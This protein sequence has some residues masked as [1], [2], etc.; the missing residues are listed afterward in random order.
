MIEI[1]KNFFFEIDP[2][3]AL[4]SSPRD[5]DI[6]ANEFLGC[7]FLDGKITHSLLNKLFPNNNI[8]FFPLV[9]TQIDEI[10]AIENLNKCNFFSQFN[11]ILIDWPTEFS[12]HLS[13]IN[14]SFPTPLCLTNKHILEAGV[15]EK[16][17]ATS[18]V[19]FIESFNARRLITKNFPSQNITCVGGLDECL[20][21]NLAKQKN[22]VPYLLTGGLIPW[23]NAQFLN[24]H[25]LPVE[26][27]CK[28]I[29]NFISKNQN[30][31]ILIVTN[32]DTLLTLNTLLEK[33]DLENNVVP[34]S[35]MPEKLFL[36]QPIPETCL[37]YSQMNGFISTE[38]FNNNTQIN[39]WL[40]FLKLTF[41]KL[42]L[43]TA[44]KYTDWTK[45][46]ATPAEERD[47]FRFA[48]RLAL[49]KHEYFPNTFD[50]LLSAKGVINSNFAY[51]MH[52][53][54]QEFP[55]NAV[56]ANTLKQIS[57]PLDSFF[58]KTHKVSLQKFA[59]IQSQKKSFKKTKLQ[60]IHKNRPVRETDT[61]PED[62]YADNN[63]VNE[64]HAY[65]CSFP[66]EDIFME[67]LALDLK[68]NMQDRIREKEILH[69]ELQSDFGDG[70]DLRETIRNWHKEKIIV[71]ETLHVGKADIGAVIF[72]FA[73]PEEDVK[74]SWQSFWLAE[75]HDDSHLMFYATPFKDNLIGPGVAKSEFGGFAV[76]PLDSYIEHPW[77]HPY[78]LNYAQNCTECLILAGAL[79]S[80]HKSI[81]F[82]SSHPP[83]Q[84]IIKI[85]K[86]SGKNIIYA[87]LDEFSQADIRRVRTFHILAE[88]GV[89]GYAEK[90]I[91]K[92]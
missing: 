15:L 58:E 88:A 56:Y 78:I 46:D 37:E 89:R 69:R 34:L 45:M 13:K 25:A 44:V 73:Q 81:L 32:F 55:I 16:K 12:P 61:V 36:S 92:D 79:S 27:T 51:E 83:S 71:K 67:K 86:Q 20:Q 5:D 30:S 65:S 64:D 6:N 87:R 63:W 33:N 57:L 1:S 59:T 82:I 80:P 19:F 26:T 29:L 14:S 66:S 90:Y 54:L 24:T 7:E 28:N 84:H 35:S 74:F 18:P 8:S 17:D 23:L 49:E 50:L 10:L 76:I 47:F 4:L 52:K 85:L 75:Q 2:A 43:E 11:H 9:N 91:R 3:A 68:K 48:Y 53:Q 42:F 41:T 62:K 60:S 77:N 31:K 72:S 21:W 39:N 70:L 40:E 22:H 38:F